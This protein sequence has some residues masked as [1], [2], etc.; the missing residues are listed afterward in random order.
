MFRAPFSL[1]ARK[2]Q[3][4]ATAWSNLVEFWAV[5]GTKPLG[6]ARIA[7]WFPGV[8]GWF[9]RW[10]SWKM[11]CYRGGWIQF[12]KCTKRPDPVF[13]HPAPAWASELQKS[14]LALLGNWPTSEPGRS[15][16]WS[17]LNVPC[18]PILCLGAHTIQYF[19]II[20][21]YHGN[22]YQPSSKTE[23]EKITPQMCSDFQWVSAWDEFYISAASVIVGHAFA[24]RICLNRTEKVVDLPILMHSSRGE[25]YL[26]D[27]VFQQLFE[28]PK[29]CS[30]RDE[31]RLNQ[32]WW[33]LHG[34][35]ATIW[36]ALSTN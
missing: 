11:H 4:V 22:P 7:L 30:H 35:K 13:F 33:D 21:I 15:W 31:R 3:L 8:S 1:S 32:P 16:M 18:S 25:T 2:F 24:I 9:I 26:P 20:V 19:G 23:W 36:R 6:A 17:Q 29:V 14:H 27:G 10:V 12:K 34:I 5:E 28:M